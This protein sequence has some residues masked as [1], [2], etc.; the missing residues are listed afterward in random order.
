M[1][2]FHC[3]GTVQV[4]FGKYFGKTQALKYTFYGEVGIPWTCSNIAT[5]QY[6]SSV[7]RTAISWFLFN[8]QSSLPNTKSFVIWL[9]KSFG[10]WDKTSVWVLEREITNLE[11]TTHHLSALYHTGVHLT[12]VWAAKHRSTHCMICGSNDE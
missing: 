6:Y 11:K 4:I 10:R 7:G 1:I 12:R 2:I 9:S 5:Y 8:D 3:H